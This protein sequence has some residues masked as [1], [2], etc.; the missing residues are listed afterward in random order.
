[1][2]AREEL[3]N[4]RLVSL[5]DGTRY[6][7]DTLESERLLDELKEWDYPIFDLLDRYGDRILSAV[8]KWASRRQ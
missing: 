3:F 8:S 2:E 1:M 7:L 5:D 6:N 4:S